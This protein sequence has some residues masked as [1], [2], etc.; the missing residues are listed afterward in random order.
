MN[1]IIPIILI[2][3][4]LNFELFDYIIEPYDNSLVIGGTICFL[5][6][7]TPGKNAVLLSNS[8]PNALAI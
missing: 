4:S 2:H 3:S 7:T 1:V 8:T 6:D 5:R